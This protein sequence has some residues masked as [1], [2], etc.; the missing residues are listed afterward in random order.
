MESG[1]RRSAERFS[2][3]VLIPE[4]FGCGAKV[5]LKELH[6]H[7]A[8][9]GT[10]HLRSYAIDQGVSGDP[11]VRSIDKVF[12]VGLPSADF[13]R[14][15]LLHAGADV[16]CGGGYPKAVD[17]C[18]EFG[19]ELSEQER[20]DFSSAIFE[21]AESQDIVVGKCH[22]TSGPVTALTLAISGQQKIQWADGAESGAVLITRRLGGMR[23]LYLCALRGQLADPALLAQMGTSHYELLTQIGPLVS[24]VVDVSGFGLIG[25]LHEAAWDINAQIEVAVA[26]RLWV[27]NLGYEDPACLTSD[28]A[29][30]AN[31]EKLSSRFVRRASTREFCGPLLLMVQATQ[32]DQIVEAAQRTGFHD[33]AK[34]GE[35]VHGEP[36]VRLRS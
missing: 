6:K 36:A 34:I 8:A 32:V 33:L 30:F 7:L 27:P 14:L 1:G 15:A 22:S 21:A 23:N 18:F 17:V 31:T 9:R 26:E 24:H 4:R 35:F 16:L 10:R 12:Q 25:A 28:V 29:S 5:E 13:A 20:I 11:V 19:P 3:T 2:L